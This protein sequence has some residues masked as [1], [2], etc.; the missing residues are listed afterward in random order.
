[1]AAYPFG[2]DTR[3][4][5]LSGVVLPDGRSVPALGM[6]TWT[7]GEHA[8]RS[9]RE[10]AALRRGADLGMTLVDTAEMYADGGAERIV[11][12][13]FSGRR[14]DVFIVSKVYPHNAGARAAAEA[15][16]RS[17]RRLGTDRIDLYLLHWRG[18]VPLPETVA[19]FER[20]RA[21]GKIVRWGVSNFD[22][23]DME[24]LLELPEGRHCA[25]NQVQYNLCERGIEWRLL[26]LCRERAMPVMAYSPFG[27]G[28]LLEHRAL[29]TIAQSVGATP[30]Q[31][32]LS[33]VLARPGVIAIPQSSSVEHV[34][35]NRAAARTALDVGTMCLLDAAFPPPSRAMP[36]AI[37]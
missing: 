33:W 10:I 32:A 25:V 30:A 28:P 35:E 6:G 17:L 23:A 16:E 11:A 5:D 22:V 26:A 14:D 8:A 20:L 15:C 21:Q 2:M 1:M 34:A 13:A 24:E 4:Q 19:A 31:V 36:L 29:V 12:R 7:M 18:A 3:A 27:Q 37:L 9:A